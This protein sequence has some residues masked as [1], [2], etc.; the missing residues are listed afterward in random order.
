MQQR[1]SERKLP[2][3]SASFA[4]NITL[5]VAGGKAKKPPKGVTVVNTGPGVVSFFG[6]GAKASGANTFTAQGA[7]VNVSNS[8]SSKNLTIGGNVN[9]TADPPVAPDAVTEII[10]GG[11][12]SN[13]PL[14]VAPV[15]SA[16]PKV[17]S[18]L[19]ADTIGQ[20]FDNSRLNMLATL[21]AS[22]NA[23]NSTV[24]QELRLKRKKTVKI[25]NLDQLHFVWT[26]GDSI[27]EAK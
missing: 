5:G 27:G 8:L 23:P 19:R 22:I 4:L 25:S 1:C 26:R 21:S 10:I 11:R 17:V 20:Q 12:N 18:L 3:V 9:I 13:A 6:K 15:T 14:V 7:N 16:A 2:P 24:V